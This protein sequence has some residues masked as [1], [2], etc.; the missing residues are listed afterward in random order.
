MALAAAGLALAVLGSAGYEKSGALHLMTV[1]G[2]I[3]PVVKD[4]VLEGLDRAKESKASG[5]LIRLD[6][7]GGLLDATRDIV[8]GI[9]NAPFPVIVHVSPPGARAA[10][11]GVFL[12][13]AADVAAMAPQTHLGAAHP[14]NL[15]GGAPELPRKNGEAG[16]KP[17]EKTGTPSRKGVAE[18]PRPD[19]GKAPPAGSS[20]MEEKMVSDAAAYARSLAAAHGRNTDWAENAVR[21]SVSLTSEEALKNN[22]IDLIAPGTEELLAA[23]KGRKILKNGSSFRLDFTGAPRVSFEMSAVRRWL[24][25]LAHPNVAYLLLTLGFYALV[26]ELA[27]PGIGLGGI[28]GV[29]CLVLA[30]FSLQVL[31][32]NYAGFVLVV[33]GIIMM[34][35]DL[36]LTSH[37]LLILGGLIAFGLGSFMLF[38]RDDPSFRI[39]VELIAGTLAGTAAYF[40]LA[41]RKIFE[42][43]RAKPKTGAESLIGRTAEVREGGLVFLEGA[44]WTAEGIEGRRPGD[45]VTV[46]EVLGTRVRVEPV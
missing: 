5:V 2:P 16:G 27:T 9:L 13:L 44:L 6:T 38:D 30:F 18:G 14:V 34:A 19:D 41:L 35:L 22:V 10:S 23:L 37:G 39:S 36:I 32:L 25:A 11:A 12:T 21:R 24:H 1:T 3:D 28:T 20:V 4:Y 42:A 15:G 33:S 40:G 7:P 46:A 31:P 43:R 8:Q 26:Y 17:G 29:I 45:K